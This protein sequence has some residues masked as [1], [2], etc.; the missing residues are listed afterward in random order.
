LTNA[1]TFDYEP[2]ALGCTENKPRTLGVI[3]LAVLAA[4]S[5]AAA[6]LHAAAAVATHYFIKVVRTMMSLGWR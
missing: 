6:A 4:V 3:Q 5:H 1:T 2:E